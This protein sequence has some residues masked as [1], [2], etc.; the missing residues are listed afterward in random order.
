MLNL[1]STERD[2]NISIWTPFSMKRHRDSTA[3]S[4]CSE[5]VSDAA[6]V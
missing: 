6:T 2:V 3:M 5:M 1:Q 4:P